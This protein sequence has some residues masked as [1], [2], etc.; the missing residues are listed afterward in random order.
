MLLH[1]K[2]LS[3]T[4]DC[5]VPLKYNT[6]DQ[7][8]YT[9]CKQAVSD[10]VPLKYAPPEKSQRKEQGNDRS[11][12]CAYRCTITQVFGAAIVLE[13]GH[14]GKHGPEVIVFTF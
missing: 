14:R 12:G 2:L 10:Y 9:Q 7:Y 8:C 6:K 5:K 1:K 3:F 4:E 13:V 11:L